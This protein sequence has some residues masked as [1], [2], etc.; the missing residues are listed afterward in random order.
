M[1]T[2]ASE[3]SGL[4]ELLRLS[5]EIGEMEKALV[6]DLAQAGEK[7][8]LSEKKLALWNLVK[9]IK[10][11]LILEKL[12]LVAPDDVFNE[13]TS[14]KKSHNIRGLRDLI[15]HVMTDLEDRVSVSNIDQSMTERLIKTLAVLLE[16][17]FYTD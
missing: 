11:S 6:H 8:H 13:F 4:E 10:E 12:R 2:N 16:Y 14:L 17:L 1:A 9:D 15:L 7:I 3:E 5:R